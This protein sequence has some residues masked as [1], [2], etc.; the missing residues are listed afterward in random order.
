MTK[1]WKALVL[2]ENDPEARRNLS[3]HL[4]KHK[5]SARFSELIHLSG[6]KYFFTVKK[7]L[8]DFEN[9]VRATKEQ[10]F[11]TVEVTQNAHPNTFCQQV[12]D[13]FRD[14]RNN[15]LP[16][17]PKGLSYSMPNPLTR[18]LSRVLAFYSLGHKAGASCLPAD[19]EQ[20]GFDGI[21]FLRH[22]E[23]TKSIKIVPCRHW[24]FE[25]IWELLEYCNR[26][27]LEPPPRV[28]AEETK[29]YDPVEVW[30]DDDELLKTPAYVALTR[31]LNRNKIVDLEDHG[32]PVQ[33]TNAR[34]GYG[35]EHRVTVRFVDKAPSTQRWVGVV[36][37]EEKVD[38]FRREARYPREEMSPM[39]FVNEHARDLMWKGNLLIS[40]PCPFAIWD[41]IWEQVFSCANVPRIRFPEKERSKYGQRI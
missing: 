35:Q 38:E 9:D 22:Y 4:S 30:L 20:C 37:N 33:V 5:E 19:C 39:V 12:F 2:V 13:C 3:D 32:A 27:D 21:H 16:G 28:Q 36:A 6:D 14:W 10:L 41:S 25:L 34:R 26:V 18:G 1:G 8:E 17:Q 11:L 15:A 40:P 24:P 29:D 7:S 31:F 23:D